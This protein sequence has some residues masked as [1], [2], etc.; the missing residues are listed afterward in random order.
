MVGLTD[1][2]I[3]ASIQS[4]NDN[5]PESDPD[6]LDQYAPPPKPENVLNDL[7]E[8]SRFVQSQETCPREFLRLSIDFKALLIIMFGK[9][10]ETI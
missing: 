1:E 8:I 4:D 9:P 7:R 5:H 3:I 6:E 2:D 10:Q